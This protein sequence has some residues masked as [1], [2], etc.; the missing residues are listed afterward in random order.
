MAAPLAVTPRNGQD[1]VSI[2]LFAGPSGY[3]H[4]RGLAPAYRGGFARTA[5]FLFARR[6]VPMPERFQTSLTEILEGHREL[7][8]PAEAGRAVRLHQAR[9]G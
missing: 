5:L 4:T 2:I 3:P 1:K 9:P 8:Q 7:P 6:A